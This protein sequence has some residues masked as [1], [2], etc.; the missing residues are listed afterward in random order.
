MGPVLT[1]FSGL[2]PVKSRLLTLLVPLA[3][4]GF[5]VAQPVYNLLLQTPVFLVA[6]QNIPSDVWLV[7]F[8]L[9]VF[10]PIGL[11]LPAWLSYRRWPV[12]SLIWCW[13]ISTV[14]AALFVAQLVQQSLGAYLL[15]FVAVALVSGLVVSWILLFSRWSILGY[16]IAAMA[17]IF[18]VW[19]LLFSPVLEQL[20]N[21]A[22]VSTER[23]NPGEALPDIV[24]VILDELP[25]ATL[26]DGQ[27]RIDG[28]LF[29]GFAR[30]QSMSNWYF[31]TTSVSDGTGA[32]VPA[33]LT[34]HFPGEKP[35]QLTV[36]AQPV[37]L[38]TILRHHYEYN[39]AE[40]VTRFC[41]DSLCP[42]V[43]SGDWTR[44]SALYWI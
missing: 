2:S 27:G 33:I 35:S 36:A 5:A 6:R 24:F 42:R 18:P 14:F 8:V 28:G 38:F 13:L 34:S 43:G 19:F 44:A 21:F 12:F 29:P 3:L 30:L 22:V 16:V 7:V 37:N 20:E 32:A 15:P 25:L 4:C 1:V 11:A 17:F 26:V 10:I 9:S 23:Q 31:D 39:V 41:P 40:A